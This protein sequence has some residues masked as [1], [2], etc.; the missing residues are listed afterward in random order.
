MADGTKRNLPL[1]RAVKEGKIDI[2]N[3]LLESDDVD[4]NF[5]NH[6]AS[7]M[8][9]HAARSCTSSRV[10][11]CQIGRDMESARAPPPICASCS[12]CADGDTALI[13]AAWYGHV[14]I[15]RLL[16]DSKASVDATNCDGNCALNCAAY[17]GFMDVATL[18]VNAGATIDV[19]DNVTGKTALIKAAYVGHADVADVLLR[20]GAEKNAMDNQGYSALAFSTSFNHIEVLEVLLHAKADPNVQDE[21]GITPLIHSAARGCAR[22]APATRPCASSAS[23]ASRHL[24]VGM[25][26]PSYGI[27][28]LRFSAPHCI[29]GV[30]RVPSRPSGF[31]AERA[32]SHPPILIPTCRP[33]R[34]CSRRPTV[35]SP[36]SA[37][38][39]TRSTCF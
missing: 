12:P 24:L 38:T 31:S 16:V 33:G 6:C 2:I 20:A 34:T 4:V 39:P 9:L 37:G 1:L 3:K 21:F 28:L 18:L 36:L 27:P 19:R 25:A 8:R 22:L 15:T 30:L 11:Q 26:S 10:L 13:L 5:Q 29:L 35:S 23:S 32:S 17:H 7:R 14:D